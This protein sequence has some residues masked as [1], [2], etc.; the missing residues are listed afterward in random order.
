MSSPY[1]RLRFA[2]SPTGPLHIG[3]A[4][5]AVF[6]HLWAKSMG[7]LLVLR[8]ED[9]DTERSK[10]EYETEIIE[11]LSWLGVEWQE[12]PDIGG[13]RGPYRQSERTSIYQHIIEKLMEKGAIYRCFCKSERL[14]DLRHRQI[15]SSL[16]P[17]YDNHCRT[18]S[19]EESQARADAGETF[20][21]RFRLPAKVI[22]FRDIIRGEMSFDHSALGGD[23]IVRRS[24]GSFTYNFACVVDDVK[25]GI[26]HVLRGEDHLTNTARQICIYEA[27]KAEPPVFA[28]ASLIMGGD[29]QKLSKRHGATTIAEMRRDGYLPEALFNFLTLLGWSP[30]DGIEERNR[31]EM[32][33]V[34]D[35]RRLNAAPAV[36]NQDKLDWLNARRIRELS[37]ER[38]LEMA[39]RFV[40]DSSVTDA[41]L[42]L[43]KE[44]LACMSELPA[45]LAM[46]N[47]PL[48]PAEEELAEIKGWT[49]SRA[50]LEEFMKRLRSLK[51]FSPASLGN[52]V[53]DLKASG[54]A[55][56]KKLFWPLRL[57][58]TGSVKGPQM[59]D[60]LY[61]IGRDNLEKRVV[62]FLQKI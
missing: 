16:P 48:P 46:I 56:G 26:T 29:H 12:G 40:S 52:M 39:R 34:F 14:E 11:G 1:A 4:R 24:D 54:L 37:D 59:K 13:P 2:P 44:E 23:F 38:Y 45:H 20:T 22:D 5:T 3:N 10:L 6:N 58:L 17:G 36:F 60:L 32:E 28:H 27:L 53:D 62:D 35:G 61:L 19:P 9:T 49:E 50:V 30:S 21:L 33:K 18:I 42:L 51:E 7:G 8:L 15:E 57:A 41:A 47:A 25:M 31:T 43:F 55:S